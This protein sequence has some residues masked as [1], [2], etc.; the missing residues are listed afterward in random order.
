MTQFRK[1]FSLFLKLRSEEIAPEGRMVLTIKGRRTADATSSES[2]LLWDYLGQAFQDL[3]AEV[4]FLRFH[5]YI[6]GASFP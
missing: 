5:V 4:C 3:V 6:W 2:C 1:D